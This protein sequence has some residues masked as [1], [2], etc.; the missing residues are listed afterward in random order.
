MVQHTHVMEQLKDRTVNGRLLWKLDLAGMIPMPGMVFSPPFYSCCPGYQVCRQQHFELSDFQRLGYLSDFQGVK[1][2]V[3]GRRKR[4][5]ICCFIAIFSPFSHVPTV[6][7]DIATPLVQ[8]S[9]VSEEQLHNI[10][11]EAPQKT[12]ELD[13][14]PTPLLYNC[15][16]THKHNKQI[17]S[18]WRVT[19]LIQNC[20][21]QTSS[22]KR[23][24]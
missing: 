23:Q 6:L 18:V 5:Q 19:I 9:P 22:Q 4:P 11:K 21:C 1:K 17:A 16:P 15:L 24:S 2:N 13:P 10:L 20:S 8:F 7:P 14:L 3:R 12:S